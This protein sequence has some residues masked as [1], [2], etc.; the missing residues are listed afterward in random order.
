MFNI[1]V[2]KLT[3]REHSG[4]IVIE[5]GATMTVRLILR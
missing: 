1:I 3:L 4:N 5:E 2:G